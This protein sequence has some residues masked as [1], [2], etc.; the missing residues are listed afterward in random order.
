MNKQ[1][2][3]F[4]MLGIL[5][6]SC[7]N[8]DKLADA[9][10]SFEA[11]EINLSSEIPGKIIDIS[12]TE[13]SNVS[14]NQILLEID[15]LQLHL[16]RQQIEAQI[17]AITS[18]TRDAA[19]QLNVLIEQ[20]RTLEKEKVR[21]ENLLKDSAATKKQIDDILGQI[22]ILEKNIL[23]T[24]STLSQTNSGILAE[25]EPLRIQILQI[26]DNI[27]RS[28]IKSPINGVLLNKYVEIGELAITGRILFKIAN[29][30]ELYLKAYISG[31]QLSEIKLG[32]TVQVRIDNGK[33]DFFTYTGVVSYISDKSEFTPKIIQTKE[34][35][36]NLVYPFK[37][38][39]KNDGKIKIGMP[40][41]VVISKSG[42]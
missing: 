4:V 21:F 9:Y 29:L 42:Q 38:K 26:D 34:E 2:I 32:K 14:E 41:E 28:S 16:K 5:F 22:S 11:D 10:G 30:D 36:V 3:A 8:N 17:R 39:V 33:S 37:V 20:K 12:C 24:S 23:A 13:G 6:V 18:K 31:S 7:E 35:R 27:R 19:P 25:I 15:T 40:G 1:L